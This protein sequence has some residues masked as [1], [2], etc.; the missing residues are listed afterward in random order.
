[1]VQGV[2]DPDFLFDKV[3]LGAIESLLRKG[4]DGDATLLAISKPFRLQN[5]PELSTS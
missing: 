5:P 2:E 4:F 1:M 3:D